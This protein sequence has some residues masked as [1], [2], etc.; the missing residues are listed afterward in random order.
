MFDEML[1]ENPEP[2]EVDKLTD[3][4]KI[5]LESIVDETVSEYLE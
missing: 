3:E 2:E 5:K 1:D 4:L